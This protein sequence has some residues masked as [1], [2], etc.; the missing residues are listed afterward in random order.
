M[1]KPS[2]IWCINC[3]RLMVENKNEYICLGCEAR[4][5]EKN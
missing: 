2:H 4:V 5:M 1:T 3:N